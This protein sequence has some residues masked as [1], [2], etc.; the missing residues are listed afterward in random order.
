MNKRIARLMCFVDVEI[1]D[2]EWN[3]KRVEG[4][5]A[6]QLNF[7]VSEHQDWLESEGHDM[8]YEINAVFAVVALPTHDH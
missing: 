8:P 3:G 5:L 2:P 6:R 4:D 1:T 7:A